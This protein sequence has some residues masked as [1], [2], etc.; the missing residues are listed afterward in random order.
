MLKEKIDFTKLSQDEKIW[1]ETQKVGSLIGDK[2]D[3]ERRKRL[4]TA[5]LIKLKNIWIGGDKIK[6]DTKVELYKALVKLILIYN[7]DT[8]ALIQTEEAKLVA[9]L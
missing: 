1:R 7:S 2:E 5:A 8:W 9:F 4:S 6:R 3:A